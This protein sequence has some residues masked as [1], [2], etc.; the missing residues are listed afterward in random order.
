MN[1]HSA[2][3]SFN[4]DAISRADREFLAGLGD[5]PLVKHELYSVPPPPRPDYE[6]CTTIEDRA[7]AQRACFP[8]ALAWVLI[9]YAYYADAF[10][11][12]GGVI[13]LVDGKIWKVASLKGLMQPWT[14]IEEGPRGGLH[15]TAVVDAWMHHPQRVEI[16]AVQTRSDRPRP[17][18]EE[19]GLTL[20][21]RY[22]PPAHPKSGGETETFKA[23]LAR[24]V[25]DE[26]EREW[27]WNYLA[28]KTRK[29]WVPM[30]ALIM[31]AEEFGSGR[32]TL[33]EILSL[34]FGKDYVVPCSF[35]ELTG[36]APSAR[37]NARMGDALFAVVNEAVT[38]DGH[39]QARRRLDYEAL[40]NAVEPSPTARQRLEAK[41][42]HAYAQQMAMTVI[43]ATQH[44]DVVKLPPK[45]RRF[46]VLTCGDPMTAV[47]RA[48]IRAWMAVPENIGAL[49]RALLETLAVPLDV[50]DPFGIPPP[51]AGRLEM[52]GM[53]KSR[54]E[55]AYEAAMEA[56]SYERKLV[57]A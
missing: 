42:G 26:A 8:A 33:Y 20:Y 5:H 46:S 30:V 41:F 3:D 19:D 6:G 52:I 55:D 11:G 21:N 49:Y 16:D 31:V 40:K 50:F 2:P 23:Y 57:T 53:A 36:S 22:W 44:R 37:F 1:E 4:G 28:H 45:D 32:G 39:Q 15:K 27:F 56:L 51:F 38:E 9:N 14:I 17:V 7:E 29:P 10:G 43:I 47:Q 54:I 34:L 13:S 25:P 18:F 35:G 24:L 48:E 12:Q